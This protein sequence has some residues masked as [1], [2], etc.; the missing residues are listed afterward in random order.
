MTQ[1][2]SPHAVLDEL[3]G[4]ARGDDL[5]R[6]VHTAAFAAAD[7]RRASLGDGVA[8]LAELSGLKVEDA[9][10][11]FGNVI[12]A[13]ERGSLEA[14]GSAARV[15]VSTLLARGVALSPPSGAEA[16]GR[17]AEA[18]VW[19]S[20][21]TAVDALSALDA[22]MEERSAGLWRAVA[23]RVRRVDAGVAPGLGR[24]GAVI[25]ALALQGSS[26]PTA[27]EEAAGLA[28]E[29]RDP[30]VKALL[31][32]PVGGRAGGSV[33]KA[34]DAGAASAEASGSA[35][36]AAE[37]TGELVPPPRHPVVVTLLA[38]TGL[39]L[40]ARGGRLLGRVLLRYRRPATLTVTSRGLTVRSRTE[41]FGRTVKELETHIPAENLARAARE[42]QYPRAGLYAGL[43]ALGLGT[44][45]GVSLFLDGAR[46]GSPELLGMGALVLALGAALDF[47]L[48]HLN[49]GRKGRCRVVLV[50]RK[51]PVVAVG[52]AVPAAADAALGRLIRS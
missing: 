36:D 15:L 51:G 17:V 9:E 18:L 16:E 52:N 14:S 35:G 10:T 5:A 47:A 45:V 43:V 37:V 34:G 4:H 39:L 3:A 21:H 12:R 40:V 25:A 46:S 50:P 1:D 29:V 42:V 23:D 30:V 19:L 32:Q 41:L 6:L 27:K 2:R 48:S 44:Y 11:S 49:A 8:E 26:S 7:E 13:L 28:A 31:G 33:E 38:V 20:T 22:A 24:A